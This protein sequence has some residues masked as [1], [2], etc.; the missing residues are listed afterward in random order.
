MGIVNDL[1]ELK[2]LSDGVVA[3]K[4]SRFAYKENAYTN[5]D[6][7]GVNTYDANQDNN[8]PVGTANVMKVNQTVI[9]LGWRARAS[10][11][12]RMLMNHFLGRISYNLNKVNDWFNSL[13]T[14]LSASL[15]SPNGIATLDNNGII[16]DAQLSSSLVRNVSDITSDNTGKVDLT[17]QTDLTKILS[18][19]LI[20]QLFGRLFGTY[21]NRVASDTFSAGLSCLKYANGIWVAG[22]P[23]EV[24]I[25][26][27]KLYWSADGEI[28][29]ECTGVPP[30][31][32]IK[33][34]DYEGGL[35]FAGFNAYGEGLLWSEDGKDWHA[36]TGDIASRSNT[37]SVV[38]AN[39]IFVGV[40]ANSPYW[41][42]DGKNWT[43]GTYA[44]S[45]HFNSPV[46]GNGIWIASDWN[47]GLLKSTDGKAWIV[48]SAVTSAN[49]TPHFD[50]AT[51][52]FVTTG[53]AI[54]WSSDGD[55]WTD[56]LVL[57]SY[58]V[59]TVLFIDGVSFASV[60]GNNEYYL[61]KSFDDKS[62]NR[63]A[64]LPN[65]VDS[66]AYA[67]GL[68][69][70]GGHNYIYKSVDLGNTFT[71]DLEIWNSSLAT[72]VDFLCYGKDKWLSDCRAGGVNYGYGLRKS[73]YSVLLNRGMLQ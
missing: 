52:L 50:P 66:M 1:T 64:T 65:F 10:S 4:V 44:G 54:L 46:Y 3:N 67:N 23:T 33:S 18:G 13:L 5:N 22:K 72:A 12:T 51:N 63:V 35:W 30:T 9:E 15:G 41:S 37:G 26:L 24:D 68:I 29:T 70:I 34:L 53:D 6:V 7:N 61:Y 49:F 58:S 11:I 21:W 43:A 42:T 48:V 47:E 40:G 57:P 32:V 2:T 38:Y 73:D 56:A 17:K 55:T 8:I 39:N 36:C 71:K 27:G 16:P 62:W 59:N 45:V 69:L 25:A 31:G 19:S 20:G 14:S 28:W 60:S